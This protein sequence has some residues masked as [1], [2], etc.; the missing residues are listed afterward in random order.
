M[1]NTLFLFALLLTLCSFLFS[2]KFEETPQEKLY[3]AQD[4]SSKLNIPLFP[5]TNNVYCSQYFP[6]ASSI[7][8]IDKNK[9]LYTFVKKT[10][11]NEYWLI[12]QKAFDIAFNHSIAY[13]KYSKK[14]CKKE[15][16][17]EDNKKTIWAELQKKLEEK[18][19]EKLEKK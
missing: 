10:S 11:S 7:Q 2:M 5:E 13:P 17:K 19:Q 14:Y 16:C 15:D 8:T 18:L 1:K 6:D 12:A 9:R 3:T 4:L